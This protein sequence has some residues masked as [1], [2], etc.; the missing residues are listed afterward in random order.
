[1]SKKLTADFLF[2]AQILLAA[3]F[4]GSQFVHMLQNGVGVGASITMFVF[5]EVFILINLVLAIGAHKA[6]SSRITLQ[7]LI[8]YGVW[9]LLWSGNLAL[10]AIAVLKDAHQFL[11]INELVAML[12]VVS[13]IVA[14]HLWARKNDLPL[15]DPIVRGCNATVF[16]AVPQLFQAWKFAIYG[17]ASWSGVA[18]VMGH[19]TILIRIGQLYF[20]LREAGWDRNRKGSAISE[21]GNELSWIIATIFW[22]F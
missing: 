12:A 20:S 6:Q 13:G 19:I 1:M 3:F 5:V 16:K 22:L 11:K 7:T 10:V 2:V 4:C 18:V 21:I 17:G 14:T 9:T 15:T 8:T